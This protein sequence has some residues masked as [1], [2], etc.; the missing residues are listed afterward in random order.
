[1]W[2]SLHSEAAHLATWDLRH[3]KRGVRVGSQAGH[4]YK[5]EKI[6]LVME[7][8]DSDAQTGGVVLLSLSNFCREDATLRT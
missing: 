8:G 6:L 1:M 2:S 7:H 3:E 4:G 5:Q